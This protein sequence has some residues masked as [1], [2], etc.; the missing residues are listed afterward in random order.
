MDHCA[1]VLAAGEGKRMR[2]KRSKLVHSAAG[3][4]LVR[5]VADALNDAGIPDQ[6]FVVGHQ[7]DQVRTVL[8]DSCA[9]VVQERQLGTGHAVMQAGTFLAGRAG[10]VLVLCGDTPLLRAETLKSLVARFEASGAAAVLVSAIAPNPTGYGRV[11]RDAQGSVARIVEE[12]DASPE[13]RALREMNAGMYAFDADSLRSALGRIDARNAQGEYYLTDAVGLL[14]ADG[15]RVEAFDAPFEEIQGVNDRVQLQQSAVVLNRRICEMHMR[16]GVTLI[17]PATTWIDAQVRIGEDTEIRPGCRLEGAT[18]VG[19]DCLVGPGTR[20]EDA[21]VED[22]AEIVQSVVVGSRIGARTHV[23]PFTYVRPGSSIGPDCRIGDF[24]EVKNSTIGAFTSAAHLAYIGDAD[25]A[26]NVNY[27]CGSITVN[28][29]GFAKHRTRIDSGA[30]IGSNSNLVAPVHIHADAFVAAGST[31]TTDVP[32]FALA[33]ARARQE[34][35]A[36]WVLRKGKVR[37]RKG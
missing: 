15:R 21:T 29:D 23:G 4:P 33:V 18:T 25:V 3:K 34:N 30:F 36:D 10:C 2:S 22:A 27:G 1:I 11:V 28:Y 19:A 26:D 37:K 17:D 9:Y 20:L 12:R 16:A 32:S 7:Q 14:V 13:Q 24:V 5:W 8:G 31:I 6:V 35:K